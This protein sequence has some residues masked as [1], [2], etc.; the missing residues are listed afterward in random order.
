MINISEYLIL[1]PTERVFICR[2][3]KYALSP[4]GIQ[5]HFRRVYKAIPLE[6]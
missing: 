3:C 2:S 4:K 6:V 1:L 5:R